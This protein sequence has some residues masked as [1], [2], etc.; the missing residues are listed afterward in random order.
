MILEL[1]LEVWWKAV[2]ILNL[3]EGGASCH[4]QKEKMGHWY[5]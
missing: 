3:I 1:V 4:G 2:W 5:L